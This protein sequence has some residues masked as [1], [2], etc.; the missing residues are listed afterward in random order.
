MSTGRSSET[1]RS[2]WGA[3][4]GL[5]GGELTN[6]QIAGGKFTHFA[7]PPPPP[8]FQPCELPFCLPWAANRPSIPPFDLCLAPF[9][10]KLLTDPI[11]KFTAV[12]MSYF[13]GAPLQQRSERSVT[14][15]VE[16]NFPLTLWRFHSSYR[17]W[18]NYLLLTVRFLW[19]LAIL[20]LK[21]FEWYK[22]PCPNGF[23]AG[24]SRFESRLLKNFPQ[25]LGRYCWIIDSTKV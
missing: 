10:R 17:N 20:L 3:A 22:T 1:R 8:S 11:M 25:P 6:S 15:G 19:T 16:I 21:L 18:M 24:K 12:T 14:N 5:R 2:E 4:F 23:W 13:D 9:S 7:W